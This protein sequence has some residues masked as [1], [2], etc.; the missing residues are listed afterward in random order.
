MASLHDKYDVLI[1]MGS[2]LDQEIPEYIIANLNTSFELRPY[3]KDAFSRFIH[4]FKDDNQKKRHLLFHM[5]TGSGKTLIMAGAILHFYKLGYR[6]FLFFV[7]I[8]IISDQFDTYNKIILITHYI[9]P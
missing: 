9:Y 8:L 6:N 5:A 4:H 7:Q 3:Q 2:L 1:E